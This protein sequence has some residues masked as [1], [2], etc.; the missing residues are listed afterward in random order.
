MIEFRKWPSIKRDNP[1][2]CTITE[3][4]DGTNG[5]IVIEEGEI[6][7]VQSRKR[8]ITVEDDN[9]GFAQWVEDN[10]E[11]LL[12]LGD[13]YHYGEWA[14]EGIQKNPHAI[15]GRKF[16]LFN[17]IRWNRYNPNKPKCCDAVPILYQDI[18]EATTI[19]EC[20]DILVAVAGDTTPEGV[21]VF[22]H[23]SESLSKHTIKTPKGKWTSEK[24]KSIQEEES[25]P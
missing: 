10:K 5:C 17:T 19:Q 4:I 16:F 11:D 1:L 8:F 7:G 2:S 9:F 3:K 20:L 12:S 23:S 18:L 24:E 13:G 25:N 22:M 15:V 21:V 14:G 6:V